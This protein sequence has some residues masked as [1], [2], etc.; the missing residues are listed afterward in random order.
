[1]VSDYYPRYG[2]YG[3]FSRGLDRFVYVSERDLG[4]TYHAAQLLSSK[5]RLLVCVLDEDTCI[6]N[7]DAIKF[8]LEPQ[9]DAHLLNPTVVI[10][11]SQ[12]ILYKGMPQAFN[13]RKFKAYQDHIDFVIRASSASFILRTSLG[14]DPSFYSNFFD[15]FTTD[16]KGNLF[17]QI[18]K[19]LYLENT[20]DQALA[21]LHLVFP[22]DA[23]WQEKSKFFFELLGEK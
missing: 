12:D 6:Y 5:L 16:Q 8:G 1:M 20:K 21:K 19:I 15:K 14:F 22:L 2:T 3:L 7:K 17:N 4:I 13:M 11:N 23:W 9:A 10:I 18:D